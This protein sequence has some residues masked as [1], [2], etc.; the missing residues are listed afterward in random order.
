MNRDRLTSRQLGR[1]LWTGMLSPLFLLTPGTLLSS[2]AA[3]LTALLTGPPLCLLALTLR[4]LARRCPPGGPGELLAERLGRPGRALS[5]LCGAWMLF[6][7]GLLLRLGADRFVSAVYPDSPPWLF[8]AVMTALTLPAAR[9]GLRPLGRCAELFAPVLALVLGAV[10][11]ASLA[12]ADPSL[13]R[14]GPGALVRACRDLPVCWG[15]VSGCALFGFAGSGRP[16]GEQRGFLPAALALSA[17]GLCL[18]ASVTAVFGPALAGQMNHPFFVMA[19][20]LTLFRPGERTEALIAAQWVVSDFLL[21]SALLRLAGRELGRAPDGRERTK[22]WPVWPVLMLA[23][24]LLCGDRETAA[25]LARAAVPVGNGAV[26]LL[27]L[28]LSLLKKE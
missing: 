6:Y 15:V 5:R 7:A 21:L 8:M 1:L 27:L 12:L 16:A 11:A 19:R 4:R 18:T 25:A 13:L 9:D 10:F 2:G 24:G 17:A 3:W 26:W 14:P 20:N 23:C 22:L 28:G